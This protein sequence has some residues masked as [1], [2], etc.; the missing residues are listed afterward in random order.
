MYVISQYTVD[1]NRNSRLRSDRQI[2]CLNG[3]SSEVRVFGVV[4]ETTGIRDMV[5]ALLCLLPSL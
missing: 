2:I 1:T 4:D 3:Y 5:S